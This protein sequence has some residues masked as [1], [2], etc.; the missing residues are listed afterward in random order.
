[1]SAPAPVI[2][3]CPHCGVAVE[4]EDAFC[5]PG[6][7]LAA[8]IIAGA[9]LQDYYDRR[10][11]PAPRPEPIGADWSAVALQPTGAGE[12]GC[13][14]VVDG[15]RCA[16]CV[17]VV[18][19]VLQR[20]EGVKRATVSYATGRATVAFDPQVVELADLARRVA[21]LGYRPRPVDAAPEH[22]RDLL[23]RLGVAAFC[24]ANVMLLAAS[25]Y[26][27]WWTGMEARY[28][29]LFRWSE[30]VL[31]TPVA[32]WSAAPFFASAGRGLQHR[33]L[34][35]DLPISLAVA[36]LYGHG[37]LATLSGGD[38]YLDS[39]TM[40]VTLLLAGRL[41]EARGRRSAVA[42]AA[43]LAASLPTVA[44]RVTPQGV[45]TVGVDHL[46]VGDRVE[47][48]LGE[49]IPADGVVAVGSAR[50]RLALLTGEAE[51]VEVQPGDRVV[52][53]APVVH[54]A[55]T[56]ELTQVGAD[57]LGQR[58]AQQLQVSVDQGLPTTPADRIAPWFTAATLIAAACAMALW[59]PLAGLGRG[60][61]VTV[62]VLV[63]ACPCAL[64]LSWPVAVGAGLAAA[65][66]RGLV[67]KDG[68]ALLRLAQIEQIALDKTG[69]VTGG[70]P[71]VIA[72][73]PE[74]L[75]IAAG[76][77]RASSHPIASAIRDA[78]AEAQIPLP[79]A[80]EIRE[81]PGQ[82]ICGVV[83]GVRWCLEAGEAGTIRLVGPDGP[84]GTIRLADAPRADAHRAVA[85]L[86]SWGP[87]ALLTGD[88]PEIAR[89]Q[90]EAVGIGVVHPRMSPE[91]KVAW[92][93]DHERVLFVGDGLNDGPAL[94]AAHVGLAMRDGAAATLLAADGVVVHPS[95]G[96]VVAGLRTAQVVRA[97]V[98]GNLIRSV[99]YNVAAVS[100]ALAGLVDP[101]VAAV[102]MPISSLL[103]LWGGTRI[104]RVLARQERTAEHAR[105]AQP[106]REEPWTSS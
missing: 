15:L 20:T 31:A 2:G 1:M 46:A 30:L 7:E 44:R 34:H 52:A 103:V 14:L 4:G 68:A 65:A 84:A 72:A 16:S 23:T 79:I 90:A 58:M 64:G 45:E 35:M 87:V 28:A 36:V 13:R 19:G 78:A 51:P 81:T 97:A 89:A 49:E 67:L 41:V 94:V 98:Q 73:A 95:L 8:A 106:T 69:T 83:D 92:I 66:R 80:Q 70:Q 9:G 57:T 21:A 76:L 43:A 55:V 99:L 75:R 25:V 32:L 17:W 3:S 77:E 38:A 26:T 105:G 56:V 27:G 88:H 101:L 42:A 50:V 59:T 37:L 93:E 62:A 29:A 24:T 86:A 39:L 74:V 102:S 60:L 10:D 47:V 48:G 11:A 54:G 104:E 18:E 33:V 22:D 63:V 85:R 71:R 6:C 53:G 5:C 61:E 100:L 96:P 40:L 91:D 82:G 12:V